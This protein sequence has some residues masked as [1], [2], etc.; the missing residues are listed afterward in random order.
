MFM[1]GPWV[2][3]HFS[4]HQGDLW[5]W[6]GHTI[7]HRWDMTKKEHLFTQILTQQLK[8][9]DPFRKSRYKNLDVQSIPLWNNLKLE[10]ISHS[11]KLFWW[12]F[13]GMASLPIPFA[14]TENGL[15]HSVEKDKGNEKCIYFHSQQNVN[16]INLCQVYIR[17]MYQGNSYYNM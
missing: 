3:S 8:N 6:V 2:L 5:I 9:A 14:F 13:N 10:V 12:I 4:P 17:K 16:T 7:P 1:H 11:G 15:M